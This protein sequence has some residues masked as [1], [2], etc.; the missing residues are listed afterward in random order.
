MKANI[1]VRFYLLICGFVSFMASIHIMTNDYSTHD[2]LDHFLETKSLFS[3]DSI[4]N[5]INKHSE[6]SASNK[7]Y[8]NHTETS[9]QHDLAKSNNK[10]NNVEKEL[11]N[12]ITDFI[13][14][15]QLAECMECQER[16]K[17]NLLFTEL[18]DE[19]LLEIMN[20]IK[21]NSPELA[22]LLISIA[23]DPV[24]Q[25]ENLDRSNFT[26]S[27]LASFDSPEI[28]AL[29][30][31][32]I[33][34][35]TVSGIALPEEL[36]AVLRNNINQVSD[37]NQ[38]A[39]NIA[40]Q[41]EDSYNKQAQEQLLAL[42]HPETLE[43]ISFDTLENGD[44]ETFKSVLSR[45]KTI[46]D[47]HVFNVFLNLHS[48]QDNYSEQTLQITEAAKEWASRYAD[49]EILNWIEQPLFRNTLTDAEKNFII[50]VLQNS[51]EREKANKILMA[52]STFP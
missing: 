19:Q 5:K 43:K 40:Q 33:L 1:K 36:S 13:Y 17:N 34:D 48:Q 49:D 20:L 44:Y 37:R 16:L 41:F 47:K 38:V 3:S 51:Q 8:S 45:L 4:N 22:D 28:A 35:A 25:K 12:S 42:N 14:S 15:K 30:S 24:L 23:K 6:S 21:S 27:A 52:H 31:Q 11:N 32:S 9:N 46:D 2:I 50:T 39:L 10:K 29:F 18:T 7:I 26:L